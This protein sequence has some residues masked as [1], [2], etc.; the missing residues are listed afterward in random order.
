VGT[1]AAWSLSGTILPTIRATSPSDQVGQV[2]GLL[3]SL[4]S[5][6][7]LTGTLLAGWLVAISP[8]LPFV[9]VAFLNVPTMV[10]AFRLRQALRSS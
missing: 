2:A 7:M 6:A 4:W 8:V 5:L 10:A 3:S 1:S 9:T